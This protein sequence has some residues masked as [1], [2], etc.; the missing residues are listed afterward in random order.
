MNF[1]EN[2]KKKI[3]LFRQNENNRRIFNYEDVK[4]IISENHYNEIKIE[5]QSLFESGKNFFFA[6]NFL[7]VYGSGIFN[8]M[9]M[10]QPKKLI[11]IYTDNVADRD[12]IFLLAS[13]F[14]MEYE[15][16]TAQIIDNNGI[17]SNLNKKT[18]IKNQFINNDWYVPIF[19]LKKSLL[20][21][22]NYMKC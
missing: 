13:E 10:K 2:N 14:G 19:E 16:V 21:K 11:E 5:N 6:E 4:E 7:S 3:C 12:F 15:C 22:N 9:F 17:N 1:D 8:I 18:N 20:E